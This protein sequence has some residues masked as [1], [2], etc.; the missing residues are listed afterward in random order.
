MY[1]PKYY[2]DTDRR[3]TFK[4][5]PLQLIKRVEGT[6]KALLHA[7]RD[8]L[9]NTGK[10][11][12]KVTF[13]CVEGY[14]GEAFGIMRGLELLGYGYFGASNN[15]A[16]HDGHPQHQTNL[17]WW[18]DT[19][20]HEVLEEEGFYDKSHRCEYCLKVYGKDDL[21]LIEE[22]KLS[23]MGAKRIRQERKAGD[24]TRGSH[25]YTLNHGKLT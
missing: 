6:A 11:T 23:Y 18:F 4:V 7:H 1:P 16:T 12:L 2:T 15:D 5:I 8:S 19:I 25:W 24:A 9:R 13:N 3:E 17:R 22:G 14:Y 21:T 10:N 20:V